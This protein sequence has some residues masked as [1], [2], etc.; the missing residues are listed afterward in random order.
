[1]GNR[2]EQIE[3]KMAVTHRCASS[4][5]PRC[6]GRQLEFLPRYSMFR[7]AEKQA[8]QENDQY[9]LSVVRR[10]ARWSPR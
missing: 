5:I 8:F 2:Y 7:D 3:L 6:V 10:A 1:M 9:R 4:P